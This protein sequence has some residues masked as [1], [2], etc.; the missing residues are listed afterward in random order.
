MNKKNISTI[1][2]VSGIA[3]LA[4][5]CQTTTLGSSTS[6]RIIKKAVCEATDKVRYRPSRETYAKLPA[7][8]Q[9]H[10][11]RVVEFYY[12]ELECE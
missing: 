7:R 10:L 11:K 8:D 3:L 5:A 4:T 12:N 2:W 6:D 9:Q 1:S